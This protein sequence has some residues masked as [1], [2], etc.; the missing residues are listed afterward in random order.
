[1]NEGPDIALAGAP[2]KLSLKRVAALDGLRGVAILSVLIWHYLVAQLQ[3]QPGTLPA[4]AMRSLSFTWGGVDLFFALSGFLV[5]GVLLDSRD[6]EGALR[7]FLIRRG[8]RIIPIYLV[9]LTVFFILSLTLRP[10]PGSGFEWLL[11]KPMPWWSYLLLIQNFT[12]AWAHEHGANWLGITWSLALEMQLY[13]LLGLL[14]TRLPLSRLPAVL[15]GLA[16]TAVVLRAALTFASPQAGFAAYVLLPSRM[17]APILGCLAN[18]AIRRPVRAS[19]GQA[20]L[21]WMLILA[22]VVA[23]ALLCAIGQGIGTPG[24][25][26]AGHLFLSAAGAL[27]IFLLSTGHGGWLERLLQ[28]RPLTALGLVSYGV[29]VF[30]QPISGLMHQLVT[31]SR[32]R[33]DDAVDAATT[34]AALAATLALAALSWRFFESPIIRLSRRAT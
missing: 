4:Y 30:H 24:M 34:V 5:G 12:M 6:S 26:L 27:T 1:L 33:I 28:W 13:L 20:W 9:S 7:R 10:T 2:P 31:A 32:P 11:D 19:A 3:T 29:Y 18:L 16:L 8:S 17:D 23:T 14:I 15:I 25:N 22:L 21:L